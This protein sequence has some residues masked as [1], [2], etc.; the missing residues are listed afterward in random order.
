MSIL[1]GL[2][3]VTLLLAVNAFFV[4]AEFSLVAVDRVRVEAAAD[5]DPGAR[6]VRTLL[7]H[8]TTPL[9]GARSEE[10]PSELQS[11]ETI[12]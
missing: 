10:H 9:S 2:V 4:A 1:V 6:R 8:L 12:S 5:A 7:R 11:R 3:A